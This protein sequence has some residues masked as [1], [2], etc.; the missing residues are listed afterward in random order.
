MLLLEQLKPTKKMDRE[1][2]GVDKFFKT[3]AK[4][5]SSSV[6]I[7]AKSENNWPKI[8]KWLVR[9]KKTKFARLASGFSFLLTNAKFYS[10]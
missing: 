4:L 1:D 5:V 7:L 9:E 3:L 8:Q 6:F 10:H 2:R